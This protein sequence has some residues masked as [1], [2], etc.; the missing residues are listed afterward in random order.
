[1]GKRWEV[2]ASRFTA[3]SEDE[4]SREHAHMLLVVFSPHRFALRQ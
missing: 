4:T 2:E 1:M 3:S